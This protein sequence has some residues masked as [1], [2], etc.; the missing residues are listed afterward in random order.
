M[1]RLLFVIFSDKVSGTQKRVLNL[2]TC[3][4]N[5]N[6]DF[7]LFINRNLYYEFLKNEE[8]KNKL[9]E[10]IFLGKVFIINDYR[11]GNFFFRI[12]SILRFVRKKKIKKIHG[13]LSA[14]YPIVTVS[15]IIK[16][17]VSIELTSPDN[18]IKVSHLISKYSFFYNLLD[19]ILC[20]SPT[21]YK[22]MS[23]HSSDYIS[24]KIKE[25]G[26]PFHFIESS[27]Y[28]TE[29]SQ[30]EK[31]I[32]FAARFISRKN[33]LLFS[34]VIFDL[35]EQEKLNGW[36]VY[37]LG[38]GP[39]KEVIEKVLNPFRDRVFVGFRPDINEILKISSI[40]VSIIQPDNYP[41]QSVLD[42]MFFS[43][44]LILSDN[45]DSEKFIKNNG[46][47]VELSSDG[48]KKGIEVMINNPDI[49]KDF[50]NQ[51]R[52]LYDENFD[53]KKYIEEFISII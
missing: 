19:K 38:E 43:N 37:I 16:A 26:L 18:A 34:R 25:I 15:P 6:H 7:F 13:Y 50:Q 42:A 11:F 52:A 41:S 24:R 1:E 51:S 14:I 5:L 30:K 36:Y 49:L 22:I 28:N 48:I 23:R 10:N 9:N 2:F 44:A 47:L 20:V 45:G 40:F 21:V 33:G 53:H 4:L 32:V 39:E 3:S 8:L 29:I 27:T 35:F 12:W 17:K 46:I 31:I